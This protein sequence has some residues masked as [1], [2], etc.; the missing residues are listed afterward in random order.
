MGFQGSREHYENH[1]PVLRRCTINVTTG[2]T[3]IKKLNIQITYEITMVKRMW[4]KQ[5]YS[6]STSLKRTKT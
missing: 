1:P 6:Y 2:K 5:Q 3:M 4:K